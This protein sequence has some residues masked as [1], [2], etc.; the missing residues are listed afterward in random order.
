M[1]NPWRR[2][3]VLIVMVAGIS[4]LWT[5]RGSTQS[6]SCF[7]TTTQGDIQGVDNGSSC[8]FLGIPFAAPPL[9]NL[10]WKP[11]QPAAAWAP[12]TLVANVLRQCPQINPAGSVVGNEDCLVLNV[13]TPPLVPGATHGRPVLLWI[14]P[15][16]FQAASINVPDS[17]G[18][19]LA[20]RSGAIIVAANYRFGPLGFMGHPGL[21]AEDPTYRSSGNYGLLDQRAAMAWVRDHIAAFGGDP[22]NVTIFG[23]SAGAHSVSL[24]LVSPRS[25]GYFARAIMQSGFA[26]FRWPTLEDAE[27]LGTGFAARV[28]CTDPA[29]VLACMRG[30]TRNEVLLAF[31][32]GQQEFAE[33]GRVVWGPVVD[34]LDIPDQP[35][36]LYEDG[37]FNHVPTIVGATRDEGW[38]YVDRS[39]P[40]GLTLEQY[41]ASVAT[42]FG[43]ADAP[44]LLAMYPAADFPSPKH[45][46]S[47]MTG[48]FEM[49]CEARRVARLIER[50]RTPVYLYSFEREVD[51]VVPDL[52]IH[53]LDRNFV[54]GNNF[55]PP[56][57][58][59][60]NQ[61]DLA[62]SGAMSGYWTR[63]AATGSPNSDD[64]FHWPAFRNP[65]GRGRGADKHIVLD[66]PLRDGK[67]LREEECDF[68]ERL[69]LRSVSDSVPAAHPSSDLCG[70]MVTAD[71]TLGHDLAC[72]GDGLII[73]A[74][75][76]RLDLNGR[77][78]TGS[79]TGVGIDVAG[80]THVSIA[81][82]VVKN[83]QAGVRVLDSTEIVI[84]SNEISGNTDGIDLQLGSARN[85]IRHN[86]LR[87]NRSRGVMLRSGT[88]DNGVK[89]NT[90][91]GNRV[92][93]L[94][95][96][97]VDTDVVDNLVSASLLAGI[98]LNVLA[99]GNRVK[100][101]S[102]VS[103]P[104]GIEFLVTPTGSAVGNWIVGNT[105]GTN[106]CGL[107]GPIDGNS[108]KHNT[109]TGNVVDTCQ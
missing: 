108:L 34:G 78:I 39:F 17:N 13:W 82:G 54:F 38:I 59:V 33:S 5:E 89:R 64:S 23:Q 66:W 70:T 92:G 41:E 105:I 48:D 47:R 74:D 55:G 63:F 67:R 11:P 46:L 95:F 85:T 14:P 106:T 93:I 61:N 1:S 102:V 51:A 19:K 104:A 49:V 68:W 12:N 80:R 18:R 32:N 31:A 24:H 16:A 107:K 52:V 86:T 83:F 2:W 56:S 57:N 26:S 40:G 77:T 72:T 75:G 44:A 22:D 7:V 8:A 60:L 100:D 98:R 97:A 88:A 96:G 84:E 62:L 103:N 65:Y 10:R 81:G 42:E 76:I 4:H 79:G 9:G 21:T 94:L 109:F 73:G 99:N 6:A 25:A 91:S 15:G 71:L 90:L 28:G 37:N 45:A 87:D 29:Q 36:V 69:F 3:I 30:K 50:T 43:A 35:R 27:A 20:E 101:N 53:G 58:Y